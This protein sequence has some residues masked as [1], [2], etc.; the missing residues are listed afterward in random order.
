MLRRASLFNVGATVVEVSAQN[1]HISVDSLLQTL[2]VARHRYEQRRHS[3]PEG[4]NRRHFIFSM[5][6]ELEADPHNIASPFSSLSARLSLVDL[7]GSVEGGEQTRAASASALADLARV[8]EALVERSSNMVIP[9]GA[10]P[11]TQLMRDAL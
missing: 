7:A 10:S 11:L 8:V 5:E 3:L 4:L 9:Y 6:V 2:S 1:K